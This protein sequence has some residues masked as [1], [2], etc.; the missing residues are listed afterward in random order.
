MKIENMELRRTNERA[1]VW[2]SGTENGWKAQQALCNVYE[3]SGVLVAIN[4]FNH[5]PMFV[6]A[7]YDELMD[8]A[9]ALARRSK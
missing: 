7:N 6:V 5:R 8:A 2:I 1:T 3:V 4:P 9:R